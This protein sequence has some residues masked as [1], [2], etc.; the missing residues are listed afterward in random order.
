M[1]KLIIVLS[2]IIVSL[3]SF[4]QTCEERED[5]LLQTFGGMS[6][7]FLYNTYGLLGSIADGF[8]KD[9]YNP[10][11]VTDLMDAQQ[12]L[13][14]NMISLL[15]GMI[16]KN[17]FIKQSDK[18]Y[19]LSSISVIKGLKTQVQLLQSLVKNQTQKNINAYDDQR[20]KNWKD[21]SKL[22]GIED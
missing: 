5:D 17:I 22:M 12:K 15:E 6:A 11:T 2:V 7:G 21:I 4:S 18:E 20:N 8:G 13:M 14:D 9:A 19:V 1:K 3:N 10:S 16:R